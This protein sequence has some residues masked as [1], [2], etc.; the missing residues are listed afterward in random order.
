MKNFTPSPAQQQIFD[1]QKKNMVIS[2]SAGSGKTTTM[3][4][5]ITRLALSGVKVKRMLV[6]TFTKAAASE[7]K[8]KLM[9]S[10]MNFSD[11]EMLQNQI[12]DLFTSDISTIH[13]FLEKII[14]R[15]L[16]AFPYLEGFRIIDE[17]EST[18]LMEEAFE[19][20][21]NEFKQK[22]EHEFYDLFTSIRSNETIK[23]MMFNLTSYLAAQ[24]D[25]EKALQKLAN[26]DENHALAKDYFK[27]VLLNMIADIRKELD[28]IS[29]E[30]EKLAPYIDEMKRA[31]SFTSDDAREIVKHYDGDITFP[32]APNLR[33]E[34]AK[35]FI[36]DFKQKHSE[37]TKFLKNLCYDNDE[38]WEG[39][40]NK[41]LTKEIFDLYQIFEKNYREK[42]IK[43][44][45]LDFND[46]E[47]NAEKLLDDETI[48]QQLQENY[49]FVF[50]D[51]YQDTNPVQEKIVKQIAQKGRFVAIGDP[52]QGIYGFRNATS[53]I[54][55]KDSQDFEKLSDGETHYLSTNYRSDKKILNFV[56][57]LFSK[58]MT[59]KTANIDYKASSMLDG[60]KQAPKAGDAAVEIL[61]TPV[62]KKTKA[63]P[64]QDYDIYADSLSVGD[65]SSLEAKVIAVKVDQMLARYF[66]DPLNGER[67]KVQPSDIAILVRGKSGNFQNILN[68]LKKKEIP[69]VCSIKT[70]LSDKAHSN[71]IKQL[72]T[73][74]VDKNDDIALA[75]FLLSPLCLVSMDKLSLMAEKKG[76]SL[77]EVIYSSNDEQIKSNL[78]RLEKFKTD[79]MFLGAKEALEKYFIEKEFFVYLK[80]QLGEEEVSE[81]E[82]LLQIIGNF[83]NDK[84]VPA[85]L[86]YLSSDIGQA[87]V[88]G[89]NAVMVSTIHASK[90]LEYP[91]VFVTQ[92]GSSIVKNDA[93][94]FKESEKFGFGLKCFDEDKASLILQAIKRE[95]KIQNRV[96]E[97]MVLYVALTRAKSHL[98]VTGTINEKNIF[99]Y[100]EN[101][102]LSLK[103]NM[104][105]ILATAPE[106]AGA[107]V[108]Y[109]DEVES[110]SPAIKRVE[111]GKADEKLVSKINDYLNFVYPY[112]SQT[113]V[114]Q[115]TSVTEIASDHPVLT[116]AQN[117]LAEEGT[118]YHEALRILDFEKIEKVEDVEK[119][120]IELKFNENYLK[121]VDFNIIFANILLI[122]PFIKNKQII[123]EKEFT[124]SLKSGQDNILV[125]GTIDL[126]LKGEK[127]IL[128]DYKFTRETDEKKLIL[129]YKTQLDLYKQAIE[130]AEK[131]N[132]DEI[133]L[134]SLKNSKIIKYKN[135]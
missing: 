37:F 1:S 49:D 92:T 44:N 93:S 87:N 66:V 101:D 11:N 83:E 50:I 73:L 64:T 128:I 47:L 31:Y 45:V 71:L 51:E 12:D 17:K 72:L 106:N 48:L 100:N 102:F 16:N 18:S 98:I 96:D 13:S 3:I 5:Y 113:L 89:A 94:V 85:L 97:L 8:E 134:I 126:Y 24:A 70:D 99:D 55:I 118:A 30:N 117:T 10:L 81:V 4:E 88:S 41:I 121:I 76:R 75:S 65:D 108:E 43:N 22:C 86:S 20:S 32:R 7:M 26:Y 67:R 120:L 123:K 84:D 104:Q 57:N 2:A 109:I 77:S 52:K 78:K 119:Q 62:L 107:K 34:S 103:S 61:V 42:K 14:K 35:S 46:L 21:A 74:C 25:K 95:N 33:D 28:L 114:K 80:S 56:N 40:K 39:R 23:D 15:N 124:M 131:I 127:N 111:I 91:I 129:R 27:N 132:I 133:Y 58:V 19:D 59:Q 63:T 54:I 9:M 82:S 125:Q 38:I 115:K 60:E 6:L 53:K 112:E 79:C 130:Q 122:K 68:E 135:N 69:Y 105:M 90:G 29:T 116:A 36:E 110:L